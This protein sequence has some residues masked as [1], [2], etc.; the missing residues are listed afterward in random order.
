M[1]LD[2]SRIETARLLLDPLTVEHAHEM[3]DVLAFPELYAFI[4]GRP[5]SLAELRARYASQA[6]GRSPDGSECWLN[7]IVRHRQTSAAVGFVQATVRERD[8]GPVASVA[9]LLAPCGQHRGLATEAATAMLAWLRSRGV[10]AVDAFIH[11]DHEASMAVARRCGL[12]PTEETVDGEVRWTGCPPSGSGQLGDR[13]VGQLVAVG[14]HLDAPDP[15]VPDGD[16]PG[17]P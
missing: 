1:T 15:A 5:P 6:V 2:P 11:P 17:H 16:G 14:E 7:W 9:W 12:R 8:H 10:A 13:P 4:G 3:V